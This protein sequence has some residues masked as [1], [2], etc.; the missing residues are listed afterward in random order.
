MELNM[1][2]KIFVG[3]AAFLI[4]L[5]IYQPDRSTPEVKPADDMLTILN[6]TAEI[7][8]TIRNA[9]YDCHSFETQYPWYGY[10]PPISWWTQGHID[11]ARGELNFNQWATYSSRKKERKLE[12]SAELIEKKE[13]PLPKYT[14]MHSEARLS[15]EERSALISWFESQLTTNTDKSN[16]LPEVD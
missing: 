7:A 8:T 16:P 15:A 11:H 1:I 5:Q 10:V 9:C 14:W 2:K 4:V 13:M 12:E 3:V 6:P